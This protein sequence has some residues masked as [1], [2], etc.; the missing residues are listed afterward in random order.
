MGWWR[1]S[2]LLRYGHVLR[3][4]GS[5]RAFDAL[6]GDFE[7]FHDYWWLV[8]FCAT[9]HLPTKIP[10]NCVI[11]QVHSGSF[12]KVGERGKFCGSFFISLYLIGE[13]RSFLHGVEGGWNHIG[14]GNE[15]YLENLKSVFSRQFGGDGGVLCRAEEAGGGG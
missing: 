13:K 8:L 3:E 12:R 2:A 4:D 14:I 9:E 11:Y 5:V 10:H 1:A 7:Y 15:A 6:G